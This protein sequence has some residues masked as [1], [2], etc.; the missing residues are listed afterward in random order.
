MD[1]VA[2]PVGRQNWQP[3]FCYLLLGERGA[4]KGD[5]SIYLQDNDWLKPMVSFYEIELSNRRDICQGKRCKFHP[6]ISP[7]PR[8]PKASVPSR[9]A[10]APACL[11]ACPAEPPPMQ[12]QTCIG[13]EALGSG[14]A[15]CSP[16][17]G[18][19]LHVRAF[20][21]QRRKESLASRLWPQGSPCDGFRGQYY[22]RRS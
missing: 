17:S 4:R 2:R 1:S 8:A 22:G 5:I 7:C 9:P 3:H 10:F 16:C 19:P 13:W 14:T 11:L 20:W 18:W 21:N 12:S 15:A 6:Q